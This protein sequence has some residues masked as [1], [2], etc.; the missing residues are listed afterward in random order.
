M[1]KP[2]PQILASGLLACFLFVSIGLA[3]QAAAHTLH[4]AKHQAST[5]ASLLCSWVCSAGQVIQGHELGISGPFSTLY[6]EEIELFFSTD[7]VMAWSP[8]SRAPPSL[9]PTI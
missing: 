9:I 4:H 1:K 7:A 5:H 6:L 2:F 3:S 8:P